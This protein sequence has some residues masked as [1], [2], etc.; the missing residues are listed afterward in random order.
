MLAKRLLKLLPSLSIYFIGMGAF[1][2]SDF[3]VVKNIEDIGV[4]SNWAFI[5]STLVLVSVV[6]VFGAEQSILRYPQGLRK[7][8][9]IIII[10]T[11]I[12]STLISVLLSLY[13]P[14]NDFVF[15]L[16]SIIGLSSTIIF[17]SILRTSLNMNLSQLCQNLWK[18]IL[19][20]FAFYAIFYG[21]L[22][23]KTIYIS[24]IYL[25]ILILSV[26][27]MVTKESWLGYYKN[28]EGQ[29]IDQ[30]SILTIS[31]YFI[32]SAL[33]LNLSS[34]FEQLV[35]NF[36]HLSYE[37][38]L[39]L[40]HT[41]VFFPLVLVFNGVLGFYLGPYVKN[42]ENKISKNTV[43]K[44]IFIMSMISFLL[45]IISFIMGYYIFNKYYDQYDFNV[46]IA[47][48]L[49]LVGYFRM[50][51]LIPSCIVGVIGS[52]GITKRYILNNFFVIIFL[53]I[54]LFMS[55]NIDD[56]FYA[57]IIAGVINWA[58]RALTGIYYSYVNLKRV[59]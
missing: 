20:L 10:R 15:W 19:L 57:V 3:L 56:I 50:L 38:A 14:I 13:S 49:L 6:A 18:I 28:H 47:L 44:S 24:S 42:N 1:L 31:N 17:Y 40:A 26:F 7:I 2:L 51:Y 23:A 25:S 5:K 4:V 22:E 29:E 34:N 37:S 59:N 39:F 58:L 55:R 54:G 53:L 46:F 45:C 16:V 41:S 21:E 8:Y 33:T 32:I 35:L 43:T 30:K 12:L 36:F 48:S 27:L 11:F 52:D 9:K